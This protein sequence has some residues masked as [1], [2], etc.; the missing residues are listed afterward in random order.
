[1]PDWFISLIAPIFGNDP[2]IVFS[3]LIIL[4]VLAL[5][6]R[7]VVFGIKFG[8]GALAVTV[9]LFLFSL[10]DPNFRLIVTKPDNVPIVALIF[11]FSFFVWYSMF[12]ANKNDERLANGGRY[13]G[14]KVDLV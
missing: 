5:R 3:L 12:L 6:F 4:F 7:K 8:V 9:A 11:I 14:Y 1:M 2:R 13:R 10:I